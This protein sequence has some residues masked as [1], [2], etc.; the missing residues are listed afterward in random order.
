MSSEKQ[1]HRHLPS[2]AHREEIFKSQTETE[3]E[4]ALASE[5][6][7]RGNIMGIEGVVPAERK[8]AVEDFVWK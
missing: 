2:V 5:A 4:Y 6:R 7:M 1:T 8:W 3:E